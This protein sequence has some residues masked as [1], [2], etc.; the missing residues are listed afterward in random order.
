MGLVMFINQFIAMFGP[1]II[2]LGL[3][4]H[5]SKQRLSKLDSLVYYSAFV[6]L[7]N[8]ICLTISTYITDQDIVYTPIFTLKYI[9]ISS[10]FA[11]IL[12]PIIHVV[13]KNVNIEIEPRQEDAQKNTHAKKS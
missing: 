13:V 3:L 6:L 7:I 12:P 11:I 2:S 5:I 4:A 1:A 9:A 8:V 10:L